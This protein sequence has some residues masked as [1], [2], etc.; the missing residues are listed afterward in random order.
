MSTCQQYL[1]RAASAVPYFSADGESYLAQ[2]QLKDIKKSR[3]LRVLSEAD[4]AFWQ[5]YGYV[6]VKEAIPREAAKRVLD[7]LWEYQG[8]DP[9]RPD[10]WYPEREYR[11]DLDRGLYICGFVEAYHHQLLWDNRQAQRVYDAFA[12]VWD[13]DELWVSLDRVNLNPPNVK[14]RDRALLAPAE[15]GFDIELHW[16][17]NTTLSVLPQ[18][19]Q[20]IIALTDTQPECGGFQ[21]APQL[22]REFERWRLTQPAD[23]HPFQPQID[24]SEFPV[25]QPGLRA[26]DLLMWNGLL[27]HGIAA[28][29]SEDSVRAVQYLAMMPALE[30]HGELRQ[31][32]I[33]SW[34]DRKTPAWHPTLI[35]NA[36][37]PESQRYPTATLNDLGERLLGL[38][39]WRQ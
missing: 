20:G 32:R 3:Q 19:T 24:R 4:Y 36:G 28:N 8:L 15:G 31:S 5:E 39:S 16:D 34:R 35:G 22:F 10:T 13:C 25:I 7:F 30:S 21:C 33:E 6:I 37:V 26:G 12:D 2:T 29:T 17:V 1:Y 27:A 18:R 38:T 11:S 23:R 14:N 9:D